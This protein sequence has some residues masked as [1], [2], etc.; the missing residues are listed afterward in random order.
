MSRLQGRVTVVTGAGR[1]LGRA[2][3]LELASH[4]AMVVVNDLGGD[5]RGVGSDASPARQVVAEIEQRGGRAIASGHDIADWDQA[6][7]LVAFAVEHFGDLHVLVNNAGIL[8]DRTLANMSSDE[9][10]AVLRVHLKGAAAMTRHAVA[11]WRE[12]SRAGLGI[13]AS[14]VHTSSIAGLLGN[15]G[16]ANYS[17]A[18]LA[19]LALSRVVTLEA[20]K[21]GVRSNVVSPGGRTR[22]ATAMPNWDERAN[23]PVAGE[24]DHL[25]PANVS[26]LIAW[27]AAADCPAT[28]QVFHITGEHLLVFALPQVIH[29]RR[30]EGRWSLEALDRV[31]PEVMVEPATL[32]SFSDLVGQKDIDVR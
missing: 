6:A 19:V 12:Q 25:D 27:L 14:V 21:Y 28:A 1:G 16:Q 3:A 20:G 18:K 10:D 11:Y 15:F 32:E 2:H 8:R 24:F 17:A 31:V 13:D 30:T 9:W 23:T 4:G 7:E 26:P 22:M 29:H 5:L